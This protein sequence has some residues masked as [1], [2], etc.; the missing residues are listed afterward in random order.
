MHPIIYDVAVSLD[1]YIS[2]PDGDVSA[3]AQSG[4]VVDAYM[5]RLQGYACALM[6]RATYEFGY[7]FGLEPGQ[8]PYPHMRSYVLSRSISLPPD[9]DVTQVATDAVRFAEEL[10]QTA[11]GPIYLCGG[12]AM[13]GNFLEAGLIDILRL[14]RAPILLAGGTRLFGR[15]AATQQLEHRETQTFDDGYVFQEYHVKN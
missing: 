4:P 10:R 5:A 2:G 3:F 7:R 15:S 11:G 13:A 1:G 6:G 9:S 14:K 12:G 8:N